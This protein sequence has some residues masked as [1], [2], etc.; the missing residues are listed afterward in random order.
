MVCGFRDEE[1]RNV[2]EWM[3]CA[4]TVHQSTNPRD[5]CDFSKP[6]INASF[7]C[8]RPVRPTRCG[9][10]A[11]CHRDHKATSALQDEMVTADEKR[12]FPRD[13]SMEELETSPN[14]INIR[15]TGRRL[16]DKVAGNTLPLCT[17]GLPET[18]SEGYWYNG[19]WFSLRC[20]AK[21]FP[22]VLSV[23]GCLKH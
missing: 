13:L 12:L 14:N 22:S 1:G 2:T 20:R 10:I 15:A 9:S 6:N 11:E 21:R 5:V 17:P 19:T 23:S 8:Q 18:A 16:T 3:P 4:S 7:Y